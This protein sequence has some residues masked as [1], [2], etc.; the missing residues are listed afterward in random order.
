[1]TDM[2]NP[3]PA[4]PS[5]PPPG[6]PNYQAGPPP[7]YPTNQYMPQA[8]TDPNAGRP[9]IPW[10][11]KQYN[12]GKPVKADEI[13]NFSRQ[14][15]SFLRAG[16]PIL[17]AIAVIAEDNGNHRFVDI[18]DDIRRSLRSGTG[19]GGALEKHSNVF[20]AYYI[21]MVKS[22]E[23]TGRLDDT[24]ELLANYLERD[25]EAKSKVKG[26][27]TYP[28]VVFVMSL[29]AVG[30]LATFVMPQFQDLFDDVD[31]DLP[32][33]TRALLGITEFFGNWW[34][35]FA[36]GLVVVL[37]VLYAFIG[38]KH[39]KTRRDTL[40]LKAPGFG[41]LLHYVLLERFCRVLSAMVQSG[42]AIPDALAVSSQA[43]N[44]RVFQH[45]LADVR[46]EMIRGGGLAR[47]IADTNLF[48]A[49]ARQMIRVGES[50][51]TLDSQLESAATF[52]SR[53]LGY[54]LKRFTDLFEPLVIVGVGLLV[55]FVAIALVQAMYGVFDQVQT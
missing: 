34:W 48:P 32:L 10:Y 27:L 7:A 38:G 39:G 41:P 22:A 33:S 8:Q 47:P 14:A 44:N 28:A 25:L 21:S 26:A 40:L 45:A 1:V 16:I 49:A 12:I 5:Y 6:G 53:E 51:G 29:G 15:A 30:I 18:L 17:D 46:E 11:K 54:K 13:M 4:P 20:P 50:T 42:V 19:F 9:K 31:A 43:T 52:Y 55:G 36:L 24:L 35:A 2:P 23:L 3:R 37:A